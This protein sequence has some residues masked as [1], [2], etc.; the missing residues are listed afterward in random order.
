MTLYLMHNAAGSGGVEKVV[1]DLAHGFAQA[2]EVVEVVHVWGGAGATGT[3]TPRWVNW[4]SSRAARHTS[5]IPLRRLIR[6]SPLLR[7]RLARRLHRQVPDTPNNAI[8]AMDLEA[9]QVLA[10]AGFRRAPTVVQYH[11]SFKMLQSGSGLPMLAEV[12]RKVDATLM[13]TDED[14]VAFCSAVPEAKGGHMRNPTRLDDATSS[15]P[16]ARESLVI[17]LGRFETVKNFPLLLQAWALVA[18]HRPA[19]RLELYG[20]GSLENALRAQINLLGLER[21]VTIAPWLEDPHE[22]FDRAAVLALPSLVEGLPLVILEAFAREVAVVSTNSSPGVADLVG[23]GRGVLVSGFTPEGF[24]DGLA[25]MMDDQ[26]L[27][28][29][30]VSAAR[31]RVEDHALPVVVDEWGHLLRSLGWRRPPS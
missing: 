22:L 1:S 29:R 11:N 6:S 19:W 16:R 20:S 8:V 27:R 23:S 13:L 9:G 28:L 5:R 7:R 14:W 4:L 25:S 30:S 18:A 26:E 17:G 2:G 10:D 12:A 24:A 15:D 31:S 3:L 21:S